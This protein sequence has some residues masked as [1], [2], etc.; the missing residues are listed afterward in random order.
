[1][2]L[3]EKTLSAFASDVMSYPVGEKTYIC[4]RFLDGGDPDHDQA[5]ARAELTPEMV[6][7]HTR[8]D[9]SEEGEEDLWAAGFLSGTERVIRV[10]EMAA[11]PD[12]PTELIAGIVEAMSGM[13]EADLRYTFA[14]HHFNGFDI[15]VAHAELGAMRKY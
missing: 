2:D 13:Q 10:R 3:S 5:G 9:F 12:R 15:Y 8:T 7:Q 4:A 1:M 6:L 11:R 14:P